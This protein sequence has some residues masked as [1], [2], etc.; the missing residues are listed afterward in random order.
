MCTDTTAP[1]SCA[2]DT[3][4]VA[5][6]SGYRLR[7]T[8]TDAEGLQK[9]SSTVFTRVK[10]FYVALAAV[11]GAVRGTVNLSATWHGLG[12]Q[13]VTFQRSA[14]GTTGWLGIGCTFRTA[15]PTATCAWDT[16]FSDSQL[17]YLR[18]TLSYVG[19]TY[20]DTQVAGVVVDNV[21]PTISLA[22]PPGTLVGTVQLTATA[23]DADTD[24][25]DASSGVADVRFE[26]RRQGTTTWTTCGDDTSAPYAC[27]LGTTS[28][29][30]GTYEFRATVTDGAGNAV[31]TA[32]QTGTVNNTTPW[33][34]VMA[35]SDGATIAQGADVVVTADALAA[36]GIASR[37]APV[38]PARP[39][40]VD[41]DLHR[42]HRAVLLPVGDR[43]P[44]RPVR[45]ACGP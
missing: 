25:G 40:L 1:Y 39:H 14:D 23:N 44:C 7:A 15:N 38:R 4:A 13:S 2:W 18:A 10:N 27:P 42:H 31:T 19:T 12:T 16:T 11:P 8:A 30:D 35:P 24:V 26:Y 17:W 5:D 33:A 22:V 43:C 41:D 36:A 29:G 9:V 45:P 20:T 34:R 21:L 28:L 32:T 37:A 6:N 3:S